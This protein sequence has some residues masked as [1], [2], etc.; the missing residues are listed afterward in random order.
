MQHLGSETFNQGHIWGKREREAYLLQ[1]I[2]LQLLPA[3]G[4]S[5][6]ISM[7]WPDRVF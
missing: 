7:V 1:N 3:S 2:E 5:D 4:S 6:V